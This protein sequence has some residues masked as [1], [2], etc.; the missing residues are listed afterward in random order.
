MAKKERKILFIHDGPLYCDELSQKYF[1]IHYDEDLIKRYSYFGKYVSFLMRLK[2][3]SSNESINFNQITSSNFSVIEI[4]N[5]KS[6][7]HYLSNK[8][9]AKRIIEAAVIE[10][11]VIII[12]MPS[13]SGTIAYHLARKNNKPVLIELVACVFDALWNYDW[14]GKIMAYFKM[15]SYKRMIFDAKHTIYVT[16][17][18]LQERYPTN[19]K[20]I[21][22]SDVELPQTDEFIL[23][24]RLR[25]ILNKNGPIVLGTIAALDVPYKGQADVIKAIAKLK[26]EGIVVIYKLVGQG[27]QNTLKQVAARSNVQD[28]VEF[29]G[30]LPHSDVFNFLEEIDVYIQPSKQEGLPRAVIE[31]MSRACPSLG[32]NIAGIPELIDKECLFDAGKI[33]QIIEKLNMINIY[34]LQEQAGKN[35]EKAKEY[36]K[37]KLR[38]RREA[39]YNQCMID[40]GIIE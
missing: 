39:F 12:R 2:K 24:Q 5:F 15:Y 10:H 33:D 37:E 7:R 16:N 26:K 22:C 28:L 3:L 27:D 4:P 34:W 32:S 13:A 31:A 19:G 11:D 14:R 30:S 29:I 35:F 9:K 18:F 36:Q 17:K 40:W 8:A 23:E 25:K 6:L 21:G 1:G 38:N 20:S